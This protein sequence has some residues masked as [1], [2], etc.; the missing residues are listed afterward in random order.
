VFTNFLKKISPIPDLLNDP[1]FGGYLSEH[2]REY[3]ISEATLLEHLLTI[4]AERVRAM[5]SSDA[6]AAFLSQKGINFV[7]AK[8]DW[9]DLRSLFVLYPRETWAPVFFD[10][11]SIVLLRRIPA[12]QE[13][14]RLWEY[15]LIFQGPDPETGARLLRSDHR[16]GAVWEQEIDRCLSLDADNVW[17][18][19]SKGA[20][21]SE[22][23]DRAGAD[24]LLSRAKEA[25][26]SLKD[27]EFQ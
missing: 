19:L 10:N 9:Q 24:R 17:C 20:F 5:S 27:V 8:L 21:L 12:R 26:P 7:L 11:A 25:S 18:L 6:Y 23:G 4:G 22:R 16:V 1:N 15:R 3:P 14:I 13:L 2:L